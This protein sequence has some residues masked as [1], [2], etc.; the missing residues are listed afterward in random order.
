MNG[1]ELVD[2]HSSL[3]NGL[4]ILVPIIIGVVVVVAGI[5]HGHAAIATVGACVALAAIG[6]GIVQAQ[7]TDRA[8]V[9]EQHAQ[10]ARAYGLTAPEV[11]VLFA[12]NENVGSFL[13]PSTHEPSTL[14]VQIDGDEAKLTLRRTGN[15]VA[16][17]RDGTLITTTELRAAL[18]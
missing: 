8:I 10:V 9:K 3:T 14:L 13:S 4:M 18:S 1:I 15:Y 6:L 11:D 2:A 5:R 7:A 16:I 17:L 12:S